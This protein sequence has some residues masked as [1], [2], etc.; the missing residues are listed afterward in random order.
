MSRSTETYAKLLEVY[1]GDEAEVKKLLDQ[2]KTSPAVQ[3]ETDF[4]K[5]H[6]D[7]PEDVEP[8]KYKI[9]P[10]D[11]LLLRAWKA[12]LQFLILW[13]ILDKG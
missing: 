13:N 3:A 5:K 12:S 8:D 10:S 1:V 11:L 4:T 2:T 6:F 7:I 9:L